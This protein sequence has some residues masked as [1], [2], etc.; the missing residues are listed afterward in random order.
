MIG[1]V[2]LD[3]AHIHRTGRK[4]LVRSKSEVI[5]ADALAEVLE[6]LE[7]DYGYE[8]PLTFA[9]EYPRRPD[10]T[11]AR[12]GKPTVY[13]EH[14]GM[15]DLAG[16]RADWDARKKWYAHHDILPWTEGGG[17]GGTLV[18]SEEGVDGP[19]I[20]SHAIRQLARTVFLP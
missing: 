10:F 9:G 7:L 8:V 15:L 3:G 4:E 14:L 17:P 5:V 12:P 1:D 11:I 6:P 19:G 13:W 20:S 2:V 16:Y 18:W